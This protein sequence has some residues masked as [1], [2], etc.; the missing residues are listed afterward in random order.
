ML[1]KSFHVHILCRLGPSTAACS[2][3][4][5]LPFNLQSETSGYSELEKD[6]VHRLPK[7]KFKFQ[8][9]LS[10]L[11]ST[12]MARIAELSSPI[13]DHLNESK[14]VVLIL[15]IFLPELHKFWLSIP[16]P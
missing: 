13:L 7:V 6:H 8:T 16:S 3:S 15:A 5:A 12:K 11:V 9:I 10:P 14:I 4:S 2:L 1:Q